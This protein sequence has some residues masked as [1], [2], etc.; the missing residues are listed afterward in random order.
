MRFL[1]ATTAAGAIAAGLATPAHAQT[2][3]STAT[4]APVS[5]STTGNLR[6]AST[7]SIKPADAAAAVTVNS[8]AEV[9]NE[10]AIGIT[11]ANGSTGILVNAN[12]AGN[13]TNTGS[14]AIDETYTAD[15]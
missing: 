6:V 13:I 15:R 10:G 5:T 2:V 12:L 4:T 1:L 9:K 14:I 8:N 11:G 3:I 7:G